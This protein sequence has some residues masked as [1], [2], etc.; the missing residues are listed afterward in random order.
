MNDKI[1]PREK[2]AILIDTMLTQKI[3]DL[4][5]NLQFTLEMWNGESRV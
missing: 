4:K 5:N 2:I 1:E 3:W